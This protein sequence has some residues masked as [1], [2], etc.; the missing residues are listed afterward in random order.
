MIIGTPQ[1]SCL[2]RLHWNWGWGEPQLGDRPPP[3]PMGDR[4]DIR[5]G[6]VTRGAGGTQGWG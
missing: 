2:F 4:P 6:G 3:P 1:T 5:G